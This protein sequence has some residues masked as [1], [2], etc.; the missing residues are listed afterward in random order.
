M[1]SGRPACHFVRCSVLPK[2]DVAESSAKPATWDIRQAR[3]DSTSLLAQLRNHDEERPETKKPPKKLYRE[4]E[5]VNTCRSDPPSASAPTSTM[6]IKPIEGVCDHDKDPRRDHRR[7]EY[8][9]DSN[10]TTDATANAGLG[11]EHSRR[12]WHNIWISVVVWYVSNNPK[13]QLPE[14]DYERPPFQN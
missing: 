14:D 8:N 6:P 11:L 10:I 7:V 4:Y 1:K 2:I 3:L 13:R 12:T 9:A 5:P